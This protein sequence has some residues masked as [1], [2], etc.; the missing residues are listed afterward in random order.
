M[1]LVKNKA[2]GGPLREV[3]AETETHYWLQ[4]FSTP[5]APA[6]GLP[7]T[8]SKSN[9]DVVDLEPQP[10]DIWTHDPGDWRW[11]CIGV[12]TANGVWHMVKAE[13]FYGGSYPASIDREHATYAAAAAV[14]TRPLP[15]KKMKLKERP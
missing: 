8:S 2:G 12:D 10:G 15:E 4:R 7:Y 5:D 13:S 1:K 6:V 14:Y 11:R 3:L 9:W